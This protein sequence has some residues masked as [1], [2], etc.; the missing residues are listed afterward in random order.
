MRRFF[1]LFLPVILASA[2]LGAQAQVTV[3]LNALD[4][5]GGG[6]PV[7]P[8]S[9][10][11]HLLPRHHRR[12]LARGAPTQGTAAPPAAVATGTGTGTGKTPTNSVSTLTTIATAPP[13]LPAPMSAVPSQPK[14]WVPPPLP[15]PEPKAAAVP[16]A[17]KP[18]PPEVSPPELALPGA[19]PALPEPRLATATPPLPAASPP[20]PGKPT[21]AT[22]A[23]SAAAGLPPGSDKLTLPFLVQDTDL[24][25]A[26]QAALQDFAH[27]RA[28]RPMQYVVS[29]YA[30]AAP[31]DDDPSTPRRLA[32]S[33]AQAVQ[34]ALL[35]AGVPG[36]RIR[37]LALGA[38]GGS[39]PDRVEVVASPSGAPASPSP[40]STH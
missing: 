29:A 3:D 11:H 21:P 13:P 19:A 1:P 8:E 35:E 12:A 20:A 9:K 31:G 27:N 32:L 10:P 24:P 7:P 15:G 5:L 4:R 38:A 39:P 26:E 22:A 28:S 33:R 37:L 2:P 6:L 25:P 23:T 18:A 36:G 17:A 14:P 34:A 40:P 16:P 30:A